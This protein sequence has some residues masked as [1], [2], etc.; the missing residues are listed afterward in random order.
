MTA[1]PTRGAR[2]NT[3]WK[4]RPILAATI[5]VLLVAA[6]LLLTFIAMRA[7]APTL[8]QPPGVLGFFVWVAQAALIATASLGFASH[9]AQKA[10]PAVALLNMSLVFPDQAPSRFGVALRTGTLKRA[11]TRAQEIGDRGIAA[12]SAS[13]DVIELVAALGRHDRLTRGHTERTRAYAE[14]IAEELGLTQIERD[15]L[16]W[17]VMLHDIGKLGVPAEVLNKET[18]LTDEEWE[19]LKA[20]PAQGAE[21][22]EDLAPW[23]GEWRLAAGQHHE[24]WDGKGYPLGL[25]GTE[26]SL[27]GRI[28]AV[29]DAYDVIT[30]NR[31]YK[32]AM[33]AEAAREELVRCAGS[34]FDPAVVKAFLNVSVRRVRPVLGPIAWITE[35]PGLGSVAASSIATAGSAA[36]SMAV[37]VAGA[38][39]V[40]PAAPEPEALAFTEPAMVAAAQPLDATPSE[41]VVPL[42][43]SAQTA[44]APLEATPPTSLLPDELDTTAQASGQIVSVTEPGSQGEA[45]ATS[46]PSTAQAPISPTT[47]TSTSSTTTPVIAT[48]CDQAQAGETDLGSADLSNCDLSGI[49][50]TGADLTGALLAGADLTGANFD[51]A[52]LVGANLRDVRAI[53]TDF[54]GADLR[55]ANLDGANVQAAK[56]RDADLTGVSLRKLDRS[57]CKGARGRPDRCLVRRRRHLESRTPRC[58]RLRR[59]LRGD[60]RHPAAS[61][62]QLRAGDL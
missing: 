16:R 53:G 26:I 28:V 12:S 10:L 29:A 7:V 19:T 32:A 55:S 8:W 58:R 41:R 60:H 9:V 11:Q 57:E 3:S 44:A 54:E 33:S 52:V 27:A 61:R 39:A 50:L 18:K 45:P 20:H 23:L 14:L 36:A 46:L 22:V 30:S 42:P 21:M 31:S 49:D 43:A 40:A 6:P 47:T 1:S 13:N 62:P 5:R 51:G 59:N 48:A 37:V 38:T 4:P 34:Q 56:F 35:L 25:A 2:E 15:K 24:R 17:A